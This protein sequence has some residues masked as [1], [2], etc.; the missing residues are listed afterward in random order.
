MSITA[1]LSTIP[2]LRLNASR[3]E[4]HTKSKQ[5]TIDRKN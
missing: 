4:A 3:P 1:I 2:C 5:L